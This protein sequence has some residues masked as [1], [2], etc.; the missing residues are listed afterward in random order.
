MAAIRR[1]ADNARDF[2]REA[3]A[4]VALPAATGILAFLTGDPAVAV[5]E[6]GR[7]LPR[8][9]EVGGSHAQRDLFEQIYLEALLAAGRWSLAQQQLEQRR[10]FD[11]DGVPLNS[12]LAAVY[13]V[14]GLPRQAAQAARRAER[15]RTPEA[16]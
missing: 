12:K 14:L 16:A 7:A 15:A 5:R 6:L 9:V 2:A 1:Q 13:E 10:S 3:W 8:M 11:P 4:E